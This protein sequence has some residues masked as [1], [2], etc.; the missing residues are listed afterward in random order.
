MSYQ[1]MTSVTEAISAL[2]SPY[3]PIQLIKHYKG[4]T[5]NQPGHIVEIN[6][7]FA[8]IQ[9]SQRLTFH[10]LSGLIH[11]RSE[12]FPGAI[13]ATIHPVDYT[14]GTFQLSG[15]A[16]GDWRERKSE[17]VQP[18][19]PTYINLQFHRKVYRACLE[20]IS[21]EG[22]GILVNK[23]LDPDDKL[24]PGT[25]IILEFRLVPEQLISNLKGLIV[26]K[27]NTGKQIVKYGLQLTPNTDQKKSIRAY[28]FHRYD[29]I[30]YE[31]EQE[32]IQNCA[33]YHV[34]YQYF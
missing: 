20:D 28:V 21:K 15:L 1:T 26:Y 16:Y 9:A 18:K 29:E 3:P 14:E 13:S 19:C 5:L 17:R 7:D 33:L 23:D 10:I 8:T 4:T 11:L 6:P 22:M 25:K 34:E 12:A 27:I 2:P 24:R 32:Y 31:L 30:R